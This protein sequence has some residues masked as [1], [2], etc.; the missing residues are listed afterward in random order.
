MSQESNTLAAKSIYKGHTSIVEDV[1]WH[2]LHDSIFGSVGDDKK[3][4]ML[5][6]ATQRFFFFLLFFFPSQIAD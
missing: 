2:A 1:A 3:L 6:R 4:L 5:V